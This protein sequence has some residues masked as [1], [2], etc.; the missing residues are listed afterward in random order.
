VADRRRDNRVTSTLH[1]TPM[2]FDYLAALPLPAQLVPRRLRSMLEPVGMLPT[3]QV[4]VACVEEHDPHGPY[5]EHLHMMMAVVPGVRAR[6]ISVVDE[7]GNGVVSYSVPFGDQRGCSRRFVPS[8]SGYDFIVAAWGNGSFYAFSLAEKV[9][10]LLGLT[11]NCIGND[12]QRL[13]YDDL[14]VPEFAVARGEVS[15]E[16]QFEFKRNVLWTMSNEYLRRYLWLRAARGVRVFYYEARLADTPV[17]RALMAGQPHSSHRPADGVGW[18]D[19]ELMEHQGAILL[20][21]WASVEAVMPVLCPEQSANGILWP[22]L[23]GAMTHERANAMHHHTVYI[24]DGFLQKYEQNA[25]Y[26]SIPFHYYGAWH[27]NPS[28]KGQW[29][30]TDCSRVGRNLIEVPIR[31]LYK[32]KPDR[33]ILHAHAFV[34]DPATVALTDM[35][36]EH[37]AAKTQR[38]LDALLLLGDGL[39]ALGAT[40]GLQKAAADLVGFSRAELKAN[41]WTAYPAL[42]RLAQVAPLDLSQQAFLARCKSLHELWQRVPNGYLKSLL[43]RA[44]CPKAAVKNLGSL[45]LLQALHVVVGFLNLHKETGDTFASVKEPEGWAVRSVNLAPLFLNNDLRIADAHEAVNECLNTLRLLGFDT[46]NLNAGYGKAFDFIM[47]GVIRALASVGQSID[48][49]VRRQ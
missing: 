32:P 8:L 14:S 17:L 45:K 29:G 49:L 34:V 1:T 47:D 13:I 18:Y 39:A 2:A 16:Y 26:K 30:F 22:G 48:T 21:L 35:D 3:L 12:E 42:A 23:E 40:L 20:K 28:Y 37:I 43:E 36:E 46:A 11:P 25:S 38:L 4:E 31:E 15:T 6:P 19:M 9:W 27:C 10:M 7:A 44:G 24:E 5:D 41:G 33:E